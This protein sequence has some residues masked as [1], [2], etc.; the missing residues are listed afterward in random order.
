[1][2]APRQNGGRLNCPV[3]KES[4]SELVFV[5]LAVTAIKPAW[6]QHACQLVIILKIVTMEEISLRRPG[7]ETADQRPEETDCFHLVF[8]LQLFMRMGNP[9]VLTSDQ[10]SEFNNKL[11]SEFMSLLQIDHRLAT[12]YHPQV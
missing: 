11:N 2:L 10:G 5:A 4:S 7:E 6:V 3:P 9:R 1:M 8:F 12:P